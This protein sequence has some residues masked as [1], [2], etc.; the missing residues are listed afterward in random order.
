MMDLPLPL[1]SFAPNY[2]PADPYGLQFLD[3]LVKNIRAMIQPTEEAATRSRQ[4]IVRE[5]PYKSLQGR[6]AR[7]RFSVFWI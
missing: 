1:M 3:E 6:M 5:R 2:A 7:G 4:D